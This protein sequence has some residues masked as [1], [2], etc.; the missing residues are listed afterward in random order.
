VGV[1]LYHCVAKSGTNSC[2]KDARIIIF[3]EN[4]CGFGVCT[5]CIDKIPETIE[6]HATAPAGSVEITLVD[7]V[8]TFPMDR[9]VLKGVPNKVR[10]VLNHVQ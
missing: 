9:R 2:S 6:A 1:N 3:I 4:N 7:K 5:D 8:L 10:E